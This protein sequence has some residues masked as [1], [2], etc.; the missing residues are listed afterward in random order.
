LFENK[1]RERIEEIATT[2]K[3][4]WDLMNWVKKCKNPSCEAIQFNGEPCHNMDALWD[5]L[6]NTYNAVLNRPVDTSILDDLPDED[7]RE[8]PEFLELELRQVL[9]VCSSRSAPGPD[10]ITW[11]HLKLTLALPTCAKVLLALANGCINTG[12]WPKQFKESTSVIIPKPNKPSYST[13]KAFRPI[14]LLNTTGKLEYFTLP[15]QSGWNS[16]GI[17]V[18]STGVHWTFT[19]LLPKFAAKMVRK[20]SSGLRL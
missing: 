19:G 15:H 3:H 10:H 4:P 20:K 18:E 7:E 11:R 1:K 2:N 17:P 9:E 5:A 8:W 13:P 16:T 12:H 6:H 14:V